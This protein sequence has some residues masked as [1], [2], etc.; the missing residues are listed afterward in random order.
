MTSYR[1]KPVLAC[2]R[3]EAHDHNVSSCSDDGFQDRRSHIKIKS[4]GIFLLE[5]EG[6]A[7]EDGEKDGN[8]DVGKGIDFFFDS[9]HVEKNECYPSCDSDYYSSVLS[10]LMMFGLQII[11]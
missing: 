5:E 9:E 4:L 10:D 7:T 8:V 11:I 6:S 1:C 3:L 2:Q